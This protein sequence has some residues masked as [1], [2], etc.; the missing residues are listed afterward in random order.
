MR[1]SV[2]ATYLVKKKRSVK[3]LSKILQLV[4]HSALKEQDVWL[5]S[6]T[7]KTE[8]LFLARRA[9][10]TLFCHCS[11]DFAESRASRCSESITAQVSRVGQLTQYSYACMCV[12]VNR[13]AHH[14][15]CIFA[16]ACWP[17]CVITTSLFH[18]IESSSKHSFLN[19]LKTRQTACHVYLQKFTLTTDPGELGALHQGKV[20]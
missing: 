12:C 18:Y 14:R 16:A 5:I 2:R 10:L 6:K 15:R 7:A 9:S 19:D 1:R 3:Q 20:K 11:C 4:L 13:T 8:G 17:H